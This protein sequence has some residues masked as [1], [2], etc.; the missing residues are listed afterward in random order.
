MFFFNMKPDFNTMPVQQ[1]FTTLT[2]GLIFAMMGARAVRATSQ[3]LR[4]Y[5]ALCRVCW[6]SS[7][8]R[9]KLG[10]MLVIH[11]GRAVPRQGATTFPA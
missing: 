4:S 10:R 6:P 5:Y 7:A 8:V 1:G 3:V 2:L 11:L 9:S